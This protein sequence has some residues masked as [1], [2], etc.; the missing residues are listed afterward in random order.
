MLYGIW[1]LLRLPGAMTDGFRYL[2]G[3]FTSHW[4]QKDT[5]SCFWVGKWNLRPVVLWNRY[6][7]WNTEIMERFYW[8]DGCF[9]SLIFCNYKSLNDFYSTANSA[10]LTNFFNVNF[11]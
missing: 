10:F 3:E 4:M 1:W 6:V 2:K 9:N 5:G 11:T 8:E 7:K